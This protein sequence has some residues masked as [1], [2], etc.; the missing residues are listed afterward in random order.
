MRRSREAE[1]RREFGAVDRASDSRGSRRL[2]VRQDADRDGAGDV[3]ED[4]ENSYNAAADTARTELR[5]GLAACGCWKPDNARHF[6][7]LG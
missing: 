1:G 7:V 2:A 5:R 6:A 3:D 4:D